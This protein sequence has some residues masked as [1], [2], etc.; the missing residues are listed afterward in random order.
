[1]PGLV[2][3]SRSGS[4]PSRCKAQALLPWRHDG[5]G[6]IVAIPLDQQR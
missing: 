2:G 4:I 5:Q 6:I 3:L 1:M